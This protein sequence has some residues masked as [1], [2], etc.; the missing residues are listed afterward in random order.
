MFDTNGNVLTPTSAFHA[1]VLKGTNIL[2]TTNAAGKLTI[3]AGTDTNVVNALISAAVVPDFAGVYSFS[4]NNFTVGN[5]TNVSIRNGSIRSNHIDTP[6]WNILHF[7]PEKRTNYGSLNFKIGSSTS[8]N[9]TIGV[10]AAQYATPS[11]LEYSTVVGYSA[12][13]YATNA[14][15]PTL[16]GYEAGFRAYNS[17][18]IVAFGTSAGAYAHNSLEATYLGYSSGRYAGQ[19][20][21]STMVGLNAGRYATNANRVVFIGRGAGSGGDGAHDTVA[22]GIDAAKTNKAGRNVI[23]GG[24]SA[25]NS[26]NDSEVVYVGYGSGSD[27]GTITNSVAVGPRAKATAS[28]QVVIGNTNTTST[29]LFGVVDAGGITTNLPIGGITLC[30]TNGIIKRIQ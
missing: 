23:I 12:G 3:S 2:T 16:F 29:K 1:N 6:T 17:H 7:D 25:P 5:V 9:L 8:S 19:S 20:D 26:T 11:S 4:T 22:I 27:G 14:L 24:Y 10:A 13:T 28:N 18:E 21:Y 30:I 15:R